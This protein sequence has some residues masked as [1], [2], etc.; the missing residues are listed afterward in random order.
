MTL[1]QFEKFLNARSPLPLLVQIALSHYQFEAIHPFIDGNGRLGRL[2]IP[3]VLQRESRIV[4]PLLYVSAYF[5]ENRERYVDALLRVST[6]GAWSE[7]IEFFLRGVI[8]Q[9]NDTVARVRRLQELQSS[10][11][12]LAAQATNSRHAHSVVDL[13]FAAPAIRVRDVEEATGMSFPGA[14]KL[15]EKLV[16]ADILEE[17]TGNRR[18]GVFL[19]NAA[20]AVTDE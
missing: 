11:Y 3:L 16:E 7:W 18:N 20:L 8:E 13:L 1:D 10:W 15:I 9:A 4:Q 6:H 17:I 5:E 19:A 12:A 2:L 14:I